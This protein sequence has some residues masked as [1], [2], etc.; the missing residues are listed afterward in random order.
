[1]SLDIPETNDPGSRQV[2]D[3]IPPTTL[4]ALQ[5][6]VSTTFTSLQSR[7]SVS[8]AEFN[9]VALDDEPLF[10]PVTL[11]S[12]RGSTDSLLPLPADDRDQRTDNACDEAPTSTSTKHKKTVS[13]TTIR[14]PR[15]QSFFGLPDTTVKS[16]RGSIDGQQKLQEEFARIHKEV[17]DAADTS[18]DNVIDWGMS[19]HLLSAPTISTHLFQIFG[20]LSSPVSKM[21]EDLVV[22]YIHASYIRLPGICCRTS[23]RA[24]SCHSEGY[25]SNY[26]WNDVA[27]YVTHPALYMRDI[28]NQQ[29]PA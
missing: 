17:E 7:E 21:G 14:S 22:L 23:G 1:M 11:A 24:G 9:D 18:A 4:E 27:T 29:G 20:V 15:R 16:N 25:T 3:S 19:C 10:S 12:R 28:S 6:P 2:T 13:T 5:S 26:S 8:E